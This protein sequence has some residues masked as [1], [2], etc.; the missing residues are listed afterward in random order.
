MFQT[1]N[2][3]HLQEMEKLLGELKSDMA[4]LKKIDDIHQGVSDT[5]ADLEHLSKLPYAKGAAF[6]SGLWEH[7][8]RCLRGTRVNLLQ[9]IRTWSEIASD[10]GIYWLN[11]LAGTGKSTIA[12][13]VARDCHDQ[14]RLGASFFFSRGQGDLGHAAKFFTSLATQLANTIYALKPYV[15]SAIAENP[16]ISERGIAEQ[17]KYLI[18][19][20]LSNVKDVSLQSRQFILVIDALDECFCD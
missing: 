15:C 1:G 3:E 18:F 7:K 5:K 20:P 17:W 8:A 4:P 6:N 13:T 2:S 16:D 9:E 19:Q 14:K 11:G 10:A 12:R